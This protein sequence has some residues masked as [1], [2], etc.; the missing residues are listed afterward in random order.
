MFTFMFMFMSSCVMFMFMSCSCVS[1]RVRVLCVLN[2]RNYVVVCA[3]RDVAANRCGRAR[4]LREQNRGGPAPWSV[5]GAVVM[6]LYGGSP[7]KE[8][9]GMVDL[10]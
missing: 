3:E 8:G 6:R 4:F 7:M 9:P 10:V 1:V 2:A 5:C